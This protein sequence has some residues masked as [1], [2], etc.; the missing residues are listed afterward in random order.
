MVSYTIKRCF[1]YQYHSNNDRASEVVT[2]KKH[3]MYEDPHPFPRTFCFPRKGDLSVAQ[4][5]GRWTRVQQVTALHGFNS[6]PLNYRATILGKLFTPVCLC[7]PSNI[8]WYLARALMLTR[9]LYGSGM[10]SNEQIEYCSS[11]FCSDL[12]SLEP[13]YKLPTYFCPQS[14]QSDY[15][16]PQLLMVRGRA[17]DI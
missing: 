7:S 11:A 15:I 14:L 10:G 13:Q 8:I 2:V 9:R 4:Q 17:L 6:Q 5:L 3:Q 12:D 16:V 1:M